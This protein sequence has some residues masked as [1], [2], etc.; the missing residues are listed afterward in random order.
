MVLHLLTIAPLICLP[1]YAVLLLTGSNTELVFSQELFGSCQ[2]GTHPTKRRLEW[3]CLV[4]GERFPR[5][6]MH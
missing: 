3:L 1:E 6:S 2:N 4:G 5:K